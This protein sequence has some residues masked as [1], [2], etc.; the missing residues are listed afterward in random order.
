MIYTSSSE[1]QS[2]IV[3]SNWTSQSK[4]QIQAPNYDSTHRPLPAM[5]SFVYSTSKVMISSKKKNLSPII[6]TFSF[7]RMAKGH[8][9]KRLDSGDSPT[10]LDSLGRS[11]CC[12]CLPRCCRRPRK[13]HPASPSSTITYRRQAVRSVQ[14]TQARRRAGRMHACPVKRRR[15]SSAGRI[16]S[17]SDY[18]V[19]ESSLSYE[20]RLQ[21]SPMASPPSGLHIFNHRFFSPHLPEP[22]ATDESRTGQENF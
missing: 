15:V 1:W 17:P 14:L 21:P 9:N 22:K 4:N 2:A 5:H 6:Y 11:H 16:V 7:I 3:T 19:V 12:I 20:C 13:K 18:P 8:C 10:G